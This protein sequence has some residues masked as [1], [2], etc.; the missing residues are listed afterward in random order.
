MM[1][2]AHRVPLVITVFMNLLDASKVLARGS[3]D[4]SECTD[5]G[6]IPEYASTVRQYSA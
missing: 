2:T 3:K 1:G 4:S 5:V 6:T